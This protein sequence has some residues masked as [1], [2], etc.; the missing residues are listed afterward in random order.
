MR[1]KGQP[2]GMVLVATKL[3]QE[4]S[5]PRIP[6]FFFQNPANNS[7]PNSHSATARK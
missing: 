6:S 5:A 1:E 4:P 2:S 7:A 3:K